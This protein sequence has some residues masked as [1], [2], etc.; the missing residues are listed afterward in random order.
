MKSSNDSEKRER[1]IV[2]RRI[3]NFLHT[4]LLE[5]KA[6]YHHRSLFDSLVF[7]ASEYL[8]SEAAFHA[9]T[10]Q[11]RAEAGRRVN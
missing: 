4:R 7:C 5:I 2:T 3:P 10:A 11:N 9:I 8:K 6:Q 1:N